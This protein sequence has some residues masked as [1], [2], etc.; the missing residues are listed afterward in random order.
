MKEGDVGFGGGEE[1][2]ADV[3]RMA[4]YVGY[5]YFACCGGKVGVL[6]SAGFVAQMQAG[7]RERA[8][9]EIIIAALSEHGS[10]LGLV[11]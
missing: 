8:R 9:R 1:G 5:M 4:E 2:E 3:I 6:I 11:C 10:L 7:K